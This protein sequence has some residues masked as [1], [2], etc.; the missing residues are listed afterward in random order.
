[1]TSTR[2]HLRLHAATVFVRDLDAS[3]CYY[4]DVLG[5]GVVTNRHLE[6]SHPWVALVPPDGTAV[7]SLVRGDTPETAALVGQDTRCVFVTDDVE[8]VYATWRAAG[9]RLQ[10]PPV[11]A[12]WG[13]VFTRLEDPDGNTFLVVSVDPMTRQ[14]ERER[15]EAAARAEAERRAA[16]ERAIARDV[17]A[18]LFPQTRPSVAT[19]DVAG[20][21]L[22][23]RQVGGDYYDYLTLGPDHVGVLVGDIAGKGM[24]A[25]LLMAHLQASVRSQAAAAAGDLA[26]MLDAVHARFVAST[27]SHA[28]ATLFFGAFDTT[29]RVLRYAN[30]GHPPALLRRGDTVRR[31]GATAPVLG[32]IDPW[33]SVVETCVLAPGDVLVLYSDGVTEATDAAGEEYGHERLARCL[34]AHADDGAEVLLGAI[35]D[36]VRSFGVAEHA[37]DITVV[38]AHVR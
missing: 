12:E 23:A 30:C 24:P 18:R 5:F 19:L 33:H 2:P 6:P 9:A 7:L 17:Q 13:G 34:R 35:V 27:P 32:L 38:V 8:G 36:E 14:L 26:G 16:H 11:R 22:Q 25:A 37:D 20:A 28:Y 10:E 3:V 21:C 29:T 15:A 31:L 4:R 1:M